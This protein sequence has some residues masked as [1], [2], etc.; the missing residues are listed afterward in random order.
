MVGEFATNPLHMLCLQHSAAPRTWVLQLDVI[1]HHRLLS[2][3]LFPGAGR[4]CRR[5]L[6]VVGLPWPPSCWLHGALLLAR[7]QV[8]GTHPHIARTAAL[9]IAATVQTHQ[10]PQSVNSQRYVAQCVLLVGHQREVAQAPVG[11]APRGSLGVV[12]GALHCLQ[13]GF[14]GL[15]IVQRKVTQCSVEE[16]LANTHKHAHTQH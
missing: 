2:L 9:R 11:V 10:C 16:F 14:Q 15:D 6:L 5:S 7:R 4:G 8:P 3:L 13:A 1:H 12:S